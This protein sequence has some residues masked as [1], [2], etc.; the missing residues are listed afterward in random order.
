MTGRHPG[1]QQAVEGRKHVWTVPLA[2]GSVRAVRERSERALVLFGLDSSSTLFGAVL[3]VVSELV[4][5][6]I[7]HAQHSPDAEVTLHMTEHLLVVSV[8]DLDSRPLTLADASRTSGQG[9]RAVADLARAFGGDVRI[10]PSSGGRGKTIVVRF[11][12]PEGTP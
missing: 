3:L 11:I 4:T 2:P 8:G 6:A 12:L 5:N 7:R 9:L 10:E 1:G